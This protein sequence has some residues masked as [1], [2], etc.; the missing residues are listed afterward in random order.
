MFAKIR[1]VY[2]IFIVLLFVGI[3]IPFVAIFR[4]QNN[5]FR[6]WTSK[7]I[8]MFSGIKIEV[9][10]KPDPKANMFILNH[11]HLMDIL[12]LEFISGKKIDVSWVAKM[13]LFKIKYFG[14]ALS[15]TDMISLN[16]EDRKGIIK[17]LKDVK[18]KVAQDRTISIF[19]EGTRYP[20]NDFL[21]FKSG[22]EI[23]SNKLKL[24]VQPVV[25]INT[26]LLQD[27]KVVFLDSFD[28]TKEKEWLQE[29]RTKMLNIFLE[30][31]KK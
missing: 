22:A 2:V 18:E 8:I 30:N 12:V 17:L 10:G 29:S 3:M 21:P 23:I 1:L 9:I 6:Y 19:P 11:K 16:R 26:N 28:A 20:K 25:L 31:S 27:I 15:L 24:K 5:I 13:E 7:L 4:K 14:L